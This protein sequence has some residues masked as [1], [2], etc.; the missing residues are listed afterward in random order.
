MKKSILFV[1][2]LI[3]LLSC[4]GNNDKGFPD[5]FPGDTNP[6][7]FNIEDKGKIVR[8]LTSQESTLINSTIDNAEKNN[9]YS[10]IKEETITFKARDYTR[11]FA[12]EFAQGY[13]V[14][15][16]KIDGTVTIY[17]QDP[18]NPVKDVDPIQYLRKVTESDLTT[19]YD[20]SYGRKTERNNISTYNYLAKKN[21]AID[22]SIVEEDIDAN[23]TYYQSFDGGYEE[24]KDPV[25]HGQLHNKVDSDVYWYE[26]DITISPA[27]S[28]FNTDEATTVPGVN[29][30]GNPVLIKEI[31]K[32]YGEKGIYKFEDGREYRAAINTLIVT[33]LIAEKT[34]NDE[35]YMVNYSR[36][37]TETVITSN[38]IQPNVPISYLSNPIV[39]AYSEET[40]TY[41]DELSEAHKTQIP[42]EMPSIEEESL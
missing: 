41:S 8:P 10:N 38:V 3:P 25:S 27:D 1:F 20:Y 2:T 36:H 24:N 30:Y 11:A 13:D 34:T 31:H 19:L 14:S 21:D 6:I 33:T 37:Y 26:P 18:N 29:T 17:R 28:I 5:P 15:N 9:Y 42:D 22:K 16:K 12:G 39:I 4:C 7:G 23:F 35:W 32:P 40:H